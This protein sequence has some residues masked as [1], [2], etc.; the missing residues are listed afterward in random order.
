MSKVNT[1]AL[2]ADAGRIASAFIKA[3]L[4]SITATQ[5]VDLHGTRGL[6][7]VVIAAVV[8]GGTAALRALEALLGLAPAIV[9]T[10]ETG[11]DS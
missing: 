9:S 5:I 3:A 7:G 10:D 2:R 6:Q 4:A 8:A 1:T 11:A